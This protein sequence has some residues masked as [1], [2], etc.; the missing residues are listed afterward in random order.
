[1]GAQARLYTSAGKLKKSSTMKY[2][3]SP[4]AAIVVYSPRVKT[5]TTYYYAQSK[6]RLYNGNGYN[7][8]SALKSPNS[9]SAGLEVK[10]IEFEKVVFRGEELTYGLGLQADGAGDEPDLIEAVGIHGECGYVLSNDLSAH[11]STPS[12]AIQ[13]TAA[14]G[15]EFAIPVYSLDGNIVDS[16]VVGK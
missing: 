14:K 2:N 10:D 1:M 4:L 3:D 13:V 16:F 12:D 9:R 15:G 6:V 7:S 11:V 8:Y 5:G